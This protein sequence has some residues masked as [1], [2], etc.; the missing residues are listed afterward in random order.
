MM[1]SVVLSLFF[2]FFN[3]QSVCENF[4]SCGVFSHQR[5][6]FTPLRRPGKK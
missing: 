1:I 4:C 3:S 5:F 6:I 2:F